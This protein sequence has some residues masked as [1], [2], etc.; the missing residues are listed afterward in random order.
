MIF[1]KRISALAP[2]RTEQCILMG[3]NP[4]N[5]SATWRLVMAF[6]SGTVFPITIS[7]KTEDVAMAAPHPNVLNVARETRPLVKFQ[8]QA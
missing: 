1:P 2:P 7:V 3:G 6:S 5:A 4:P 8:V